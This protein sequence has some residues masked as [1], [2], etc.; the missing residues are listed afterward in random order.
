MGSAAAAVTAGLA[1]APGR[2]GGD[3]GGRLGLLGARRGLYPEPGPGAEIGATDLAERGT[4]EVAVP[5]AG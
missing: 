5:R 1:E 2:R 4:R 3:G